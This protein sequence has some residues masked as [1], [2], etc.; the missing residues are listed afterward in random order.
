ME[1]QVRR[2]LAAALRPKQHRSMGSTIIRSCTCRLSRR[3]RLCADGW[4]RNCRPKPNGNSPRA[5]GS[6]ARNSPGAMSSCPAASR[7]R[8]PGKA[9]FPQQNLADRR[10]RADLAG[11]AFPP[12]GY[13]LYDM[14]GNVWEWTERLVVDQARSRCTEGVLH[15]G[16]SARRPRG[17]QL[18]SVPAEH[19][20]PAQGAQGRLA[21]V[22]AKLLPPLP[23]GGAPC[24][25]DRYVDQSR[26]I[27]LRR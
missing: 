2:Q 23:A 6:T 16:K 1:F 19:Q 27:S 20:D 25:A 3:G 18:R 4:A 10:L 5:A 24:R 7:W 14:I 8:T 21:S 17:R 15:P 13:G 9:H 12:N 22:R 26:R 11:A